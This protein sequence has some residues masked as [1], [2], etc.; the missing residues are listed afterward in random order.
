MK[1][2]IIPIR[3]LK[4]NYIWMIVNSDKKLAVVI[5]PGEAKPV[6]D[7]LDHQK[8]KLTA[9][10][11][12]HH[13]WDHTNGIAELLEH[14]PVPVYRSPLENKLVIPELDLDFTVLKIP[15]HTH[16]HIAFFGLNSVF[17]GDTLFCAGCGRV[18]EGTHEQMFESLQK[19]SQLPDH[20]KIYCGHEYTQ[21]NLKFAKTVEPNNPNFNLQSTVPSTIHIE[22]L[23]NPFFRCE[24]SEV[25]KAVENYCGKKLSMP[26][27][28]FRELR[29][30]KDNF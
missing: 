17:C 25:H 3:A 1:L 21:R 26:V 18:F 8:I 30:W 24:I 20:T 23:T 10:L 9:I 29:I 13:H 27:D 11:V 12:T 22:K 15:G 4:D 6:L 19:L 2:D 5:D 28:V 14:Y 7:I 16:D